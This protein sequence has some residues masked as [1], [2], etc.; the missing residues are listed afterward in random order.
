MVAETDQAF[1]RRQRLLTRLVF[2]A[3]CFF[4]PIG[5]FLMVNSLASNGAFARAAILWL[6][7]L[8]GGEPVN[9][10]HEVDMALAEWA[11]TLALFGVGAVV[12]GCV[13]VL[14]AAACG[15]LA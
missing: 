14:V 2:A 10:V 6:S 1:V 5:G 13:A 3:A 15:A 9:N 12:V 8:F 4:Y 11:E 7:V